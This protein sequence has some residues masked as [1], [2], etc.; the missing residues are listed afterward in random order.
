MFRQLINIIRHFFLRIPYKKE[1]SNY[2]VDYASIVADTTVPVR[3]NNGVEV[4]TATL[5]EIVE[6]YQNIT[7]ISD[8][9]TKMNTFIQFMFKY[10]G[11]TATLSS[12]MP[13]VVGTNGYSSMVTAFTNEAINLMETGID[14]AMSEVDLNDIESL[15]ITEYG[16]HFI[17]FVNEI[18]AYDIAFEEK[19][20]VSIYELANKVINPLTG[21]T[22]FDM[23]FELVY[24]ASSDSVF[25]WLL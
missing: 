2:D 3:D 25:S 22:Y 1:D 21:E 14:G 11:D 6:E 5:A 8:Y 19:D 10:T 7:K 24:P 17:F 20:M 16:I 18:D 12:G 4:G 15:C 13:Y 9:K 23:L